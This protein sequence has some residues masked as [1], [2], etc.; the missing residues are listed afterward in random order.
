M[1]LKQ[2][3]QGV[4]QGLHSTATLRNQRRQ[5]AKNVLFSDVF[6]V[7]EE[8]GYIGMRVFGDEMPDGCGPAGCHERKTQ[9]IWIELITYE[10]IVLPAPAFWMLLSASRLPYLTQCKIRTH[11]MQP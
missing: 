2:T 10:R 3:E 4:R 8:V 1:P 6:E 5:Q 9:K 7:K 11:C